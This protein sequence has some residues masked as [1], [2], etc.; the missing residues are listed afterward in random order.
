MAELFS[1]DTS[2][3]LAIN[4]LKNEGM[5]TILQE[6]QAKSIGRIE[7]DFCDLARLHKIA[8]VRKCFTIL[9]FG[10]GYSTIVLADAIFKNQ[11]DW[12]NLTEKPIIRCSTQFQIH[13]VDTEEKWI[14]ST[15]NDIPE[16]YLSH[17]RLY[18]SPVSPGDFNGIDCHFYNKLPDVVPDLIYLDGPDPRSILQNT[19]QLEGAKHPMM[20]EETKWENEDKVVLAA[21]ILRIES[22]LLPGTAVIVDGRS[23]NV[24]FLKAHLYRNWR[25]GRNQN[26]DITIFELQEAPLGKY[27]AAAKLYCLGS[28]ASAWGEY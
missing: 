23:A 25:V 22:W 20:R 14:A 10:V 7:P 2:Q 18:A 1:E 15:L 9:E 27:D 6:I 24:R 28:R 26:A 3:V 11:Q 17:V 16:K 8:R 12:I 21:D 4:Y 19:Y 13:T 5:L